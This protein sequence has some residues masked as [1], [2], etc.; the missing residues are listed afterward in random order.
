[1]TAARPVTAAV[2]R[3]DT[4]VE[5]DALLTL[6][7]AGWELVV[8]RAG[9]EP[10]RDTGAYD[11]VRE[12]TRDGSR[13]LTLA[14]AREGRVRLAFDS[15]ADAD[16]TERDLAARCC[17][18]PELTRALRSL[19]RRREGLS[20]SE[21]SEVDRFFAPL[22][23]A[24]R[25]AAKTDADTVARA[26]DA[27]GGAAL[28]AALERT[29]A[30]FAAVRHPDRASARRALEARLHERLE[31]VL[32]A[33]ARLDEAAA[34]ARDPEGGVVR[35]GAWREWVARLRAVFARADECWPHLA[36]EL[37]ASIRA[38]DALPRARRPR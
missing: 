38:A 20:V 5:G 13:G 30:E 8:S 25:Q 7:A 3:R 37:S 32:E 33:L 29:A 26:L 4:R 17:A 21:A 22:L 15:E 11:D 35:V 12:L 23:H 6:G 36:A 27:F 2:Q 19:G 1:M 16:E 34:L 24:R 28:A 10:W 9:C 18:L 14:L 31:P